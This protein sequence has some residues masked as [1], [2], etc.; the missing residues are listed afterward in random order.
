MDTSIRNGLIYCLT[1]PNGKCYVG[2]TVRKLERRLEEHE[3]YNDCK[4]IHEAI[5]QHGMSNM[6]VDVLFQGVES[7]LDKQEKKYISELNSLHPNGYNIRSGGSHG[8]IHCPASR[9]RMRQSKLGEKNHNYGK[10]RTDEARKNIS[11]AK[12]GEK[13]H[14]YGKTFTDE[15]KLKCAKAHRKNP[16]DTD[17][18][19]YLVR[20]NPRPEKYCHGG[21]AVMN[22]PCVNNKYFTSKTKS[23]EEKYEL[24]A[25]YLNKANEQLGSQTK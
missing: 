25:E 18:P 3:K 22:H 2:Q 16:D 20:V 9:E 21:Y 6:I 13:H 8:S 24:A 10:P 7:E 5:M 19:M 12:A 1:C 11:N 23:M 15:H 4:Y 14:F 17:F